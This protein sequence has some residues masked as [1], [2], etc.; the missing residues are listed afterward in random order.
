MKV[1]CTIWQ[2]LWACAVLVPLLIII[3]LIGHRY[4]PLFLD[5]DG[6][7]Q[8]LS[9]LFYLAG[10]GVAVL[11]LV[12]TKGV[13]PAY[14]AVWAL[15]CVIFFGEETSWLQHQLGYA[16]PET[17]ASW[18]AQREFNLHNLNIFQG[19]ELFGTRG[20]LGWSAILKS[21]HLFQLGFFAYFLALPAAI[22]THR[23]TA[24]VS[25]LRLP[26]PGWRL[27]GSIWLLIGLSIVLTAFAGDP[28]KP[29]IA[30]TR[31]MFYALSIL[32]FLTLWVRLRPSSC[33]REP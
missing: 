14:F 33:D 31:E 23:G 13:E 28:T 15:L 5:E 24:L 4:A 19:G 9:A 17:A 29:V 18:N 2:A 20:E 16:T 22:L 11:G 30:E 10:F 27:V 32:A 12:R 1:D 26:F 3:F 21:Q 8:L 25:T 7:I 6:P